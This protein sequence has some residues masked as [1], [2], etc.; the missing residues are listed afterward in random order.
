MSEDVDESRLGEWAA[1]LSELL[2]SKEGIT[3]PL[4]VSSAPL[5]SLPL[6]LAEMENAAPLP[7]PLEAKVELAPE[8][9]PPPPPPPPLQASAPPAAPPMLSFSGSASSM[10]SALWASGV[11]EDAAMAAALDCATYT[12]KPPPPPPR[13]VAAAAAFTDPHSKMKPTP[14]IASSAEPRVAGSVRQKRPGGPSAHLK[15]Q[16]VLHRPAHGRAHV[17]FISPEGELVCSAAVRRKASASLAVASV[18]R[19]DP[20]ADPGAWASAI[21]RA[22]VALGANGAGGEGG[23]AARGARPSRSAEAVPSARGTAEAESE[24]ASC[25][26]TRCEMEVFRAGTDVGKRRLESSSLST[27]PGQPLV[28]R[29]LNHHDSLIPTNEA[30]TEFKLH[31]GLLRKENS[32]STSSIGSDF[33][34]EAAVTKLDS[35]GSTRTS[36][37]GLGCSCCDGSSGGGGSSRVDGGHGDK[38]SK[39]YELVRLLDDDEVGR[40]L[41][42]GG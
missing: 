30:G 9:P 22:A 15:G 35:G 6:P 7:P 10:L 27:S 8:P 41:E 33:V 42:G 39:E 24:D 2:R 29:H 25:D 26:C 34:S 23:G 11:R 19:F 5:P 36:K 14:S 4:G 21:D 28:V 40:K 1:I 16:A 32:S 12:P 31:C 38:F 13:A 20:S 18:R 3:T 37:Y 17:D